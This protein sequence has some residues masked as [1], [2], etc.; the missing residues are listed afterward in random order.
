MYRSIC[1]PLL[2]WIPTCVIVERWHKIAAQ[3]RGPGSESEGPK[4]VNVFVSALKA[5]MG[6]K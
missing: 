6:E 5:Q 4:A 2:Q 1:L 3:E